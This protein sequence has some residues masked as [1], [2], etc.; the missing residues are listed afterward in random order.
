MTFIGIWRFEFLLVSNNINEFSLFFR[1][2]NTI[3]FLRTPNISDE[4]IHCLR[5]A[6]IM[7]ILEEKLRGYRDKW[8]SRC[9][10]LNSINNTWELEKS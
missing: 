5:L 1:C 8:F 3:I 7:I 6:S 9:A 2:E 4:M 10:C